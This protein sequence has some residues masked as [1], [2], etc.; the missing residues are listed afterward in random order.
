MA[1]IAVA[2][3]A[4][5]D[6]RVWL[7]NLSYESRQLVV[8]VMALRSNDDHGREWNIWVTGWTLGADRSVTRTARS[9]WRVLARVTPVNAH[10]SNYLYLDGRRN[11]A[12]SYSAASIDL[13]GG[14]EIAHTPRWTGA[15]RG[16]ALYERVGAGQS[17]EV[18]RFWDRPFV[19]AETV[20]SYARVRSDTLFG[21]RW[22]GIKADVSAQ[23]YTGARTWS[24]VRAAAGAGR[25][26]G[27]VFVSGR[28]AVFA[29]QSLNTVSAFLIGGSW[30]LAPP[31]LLAG[32]RYAEF[33]VNRAGTMG[34][35][36]DLRI[37]GAWEVGVRGAFLKAPHLDRRGAAV[38][39]MTVW[40]GA[41][42]N[43][44][45]AMPRREVDRPRGR[46]VIFATVTA[47]VIQR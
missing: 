30:D 32:Y 10:A 39:V 18:R 37:H 35:G 3:P 33:R 17:A 36:V 6:T 34:A 19:G 47:A 13:G 44:G 24:R 15:Y 23:V 46:A 26:A 45:V 14:F 31:D 38:Q 25:R 27:P 12:A 21:A 2:M 11:P 5:A 16:M 42:V 43:A 20:Q 29:G 22:D 8:P 7:V 41:V 28:A 40:K 9:R 1:A 4:R